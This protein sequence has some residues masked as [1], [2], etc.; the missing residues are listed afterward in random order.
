MKRTVFFV[1]DRTGI[2]AE[3]LGRTVLTQFPDQEF[4]FVTLPFIDT[5]ERA[6]SALARIRAAGE[7]DGLPPLV[8]STI[9][10]PEQRLDVAPPEAHVVELFSTFLEPLE[11]IL[12]V[13]AT[14]A[15]GRMHGMGDADRYQRRID[16]VNFTLAHDDGVKPRDLEAADVVLVGVSRTGKTPTCLYLAM[17]HNVRAANYPLTEEDLDSGRLP[18]LLLPVR[19]KLFGLSIDPEHLSRI[20]QQ[21]RP[22]SRYASLGQ[23]REEVR[24]VEALFRQE[25][26]PYLHTT[27]VSVEEIAMS[28]LHENGRGLGGS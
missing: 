7:A 14:R 11:Q 24:R 21:R 28:I 13:G 23:C 2:S 1:S 10:D 16:A 3:T 5:P 19:P 26:I 27:A 18:D 4:R 20:R 17:Q 9:V 12:G 6:A 8:F 15:K 22:D 25:S